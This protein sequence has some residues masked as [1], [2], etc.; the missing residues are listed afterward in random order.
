MRRRSY[1][2][3]CRAPLS[4]RLYAILVRLSWPLTGRSHEMRLVDAAVSDANAPGVVISGAAGVGKSR[5][6]REALNLAA[7]RGFETRWA[8]GTA[9][10]RVLPLGAFA[11]WAHSAIGD[12]LRVVAD[13]IDAMTSAPGGAPVVLAVDDVPLLDDLSTFVV[14]QIAQRSLAK[15][16]LTVRDGEPISAGVQDI[17]RSSGFDRIDLQ[18]LSRDETTALVEAALGG[19]LDPEA[20]SRLWKL[21]H[22][23]VLYLQNIVEQEVRDRR[24]ATQ[25]GYWRWTGDPVIAPQL[26]ELI[27]SRDR[28]PSN[29]GE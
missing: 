6:A 3:I 16:V 18:P 21:T 8:V 2:A 17:W 5:V 28:W 25:H 7:S 10:A 29:R 26:A 15:V 19:P 12:Q 11:S 14:H 4:K 27:E 24:L 9:S 22:G 13:V 23:N 20:A 1:H